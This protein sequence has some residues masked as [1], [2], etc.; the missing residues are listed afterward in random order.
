MLVEFQN[1]IQHLTSMLQNQDMYA[2][3]GLRKYRHRATEAQIK[4]AYRKKV[5][6][7]HP[8]K[9][10]AAGRTEED[11]YFKLIQKA[12]EVLLD[13]NKRRQFDS[14]DEAAEVEPPTKKQLKDKTQFYKICSKVFKAEGR[15]S[16]IQPVPK[17]GN[18]TSTQKEVED[19]YNFFYN[20]SSWRTFEWQDEDVPPCTLR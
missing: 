20:F 4:N 15:F 11:G 3:L 5:L 9:K 1:Q 10:A 8:D 2:T 17:F 6:R 12:H 7:H 18:A 14:V 13:E 16:N 19:F